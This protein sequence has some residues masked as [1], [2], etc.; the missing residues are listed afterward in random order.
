[1][2]TIGIADILLNVDKWNNENV[3]E[4]ESSTKDGLEILE[5]WVYGVKF[6]IV[7]D[8][9]AETYEYFNNTFS[10]MAKLEKGDITYKDKALNQYNN[11]YKRFMEKK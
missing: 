1:M 9:L 3:I 6:S 7:I 4:F 5:S 8:I 10:F 11:I 2:Y